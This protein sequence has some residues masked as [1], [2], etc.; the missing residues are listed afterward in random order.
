MKTAL[1][2]A[3]LC[4]AVTVSLQAQ[5][6]NF[7]ERNRVR[8]V[9]LSSD[10]GSLWHTTG[11]GLVRYDIARRIWQAFGRTEGLPATDLNALLVFPDG[12]LAAGRFLAVRMSESELKEVFSF[13]TSS[14][15][16]KYVESLPGVTEDIVPFVELWGQEITGRLTSTFQAEMAKRGHKL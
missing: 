10:G 12:M 3:M 9:E 4:L 15:G 14:V 2:S 13:L 7:A 6:T 8:A 5:W 1:L 16:K 11:G